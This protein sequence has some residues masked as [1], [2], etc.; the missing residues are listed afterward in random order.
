MDPVA[1]DA[2]RPYWSL[3]QEALLATLHASP[4]G[5]S[6]EDAARRLK[7]TGANTLGKDR[8]LSAFTVLWRQFRSPLVLILVIAAAI[9]ASVGQAHEA[10]IIGIIVLASCL[11]G[12]GGARPVR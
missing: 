8:S 6:V 12:T 10:I 2:V 9:S 1:D 4:K 11:L 7:E 3:P 5:L